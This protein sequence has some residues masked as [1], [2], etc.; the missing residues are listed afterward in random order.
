MS[1]PLCST[2]F[3]NPRSPGSNRCPGCGPER[4]Q[5]PKPANGITMPPMPPQILWDIEEQENTE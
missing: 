5:T 2:C 4:L 1:R 3:R